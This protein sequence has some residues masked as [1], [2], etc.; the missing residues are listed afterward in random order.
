MNDCVST[1]VTIDIILCV[2]VNSRYDQ[3]QRNTVGC[4]HRDNG[5]GI[6]NHELDNKTFRDQ[7]GNQVRDVVTGHPEN[8]DQTRC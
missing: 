1:A 7:N 2:C 3:K 6:V 8:Y 4:K 5:I